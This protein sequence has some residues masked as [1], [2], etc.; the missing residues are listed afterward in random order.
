VEHT[1]LTS[2]PIDETIKLAFEALAQ[3]GC[4]ALVTDTEGNIVYVNR[5][6]CEISGYSPTELIGSN[7]RMLQSGNTPSAT[8]QTLWNS[9][10]S[11]HAW[12]GVIQNRNK[13]GELYWEAVTI[14]PLKNS[15]GAITHF[16]A[17]LEDITSERLAQ[18]AQ[19][20][21][22]EE[23]FQEEKRESL[24]SLALGITE[25]I[26]NSLKA[27]ASDCELARRSIGNKAKISE[28]L[29]KIEASANQGSD[30]LRQ[31]STLWKPKLSARL[32]LDIQRLLTS[33]VEKFRTLVVPSSLNVS[34]ASGPAPVFGDEALINNALAALL[35]NAREA[36]DGEEINL[37]YGTLD[38]FA[39]APNEFFIPCGLNSLSVAYVEVADRGVGMDEYTLR[40]A[41]N[42]FFTNK[43]GH[44]GLGLATLYGI[45][46]AH[47][48]AIG[49]LSSPTRGTTARL[50]FRRLSINSPVSAS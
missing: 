46:S 50:Y 49:V 34:L 6:L 8:Y 21:L 45:M 27:V 47:K 14:S 32:C 18:A 2:H 36:S 15:A 12:H 19:T 7:P 37:S 9:V 31:V 16:S 3:S 30:L 4:G 26:N 17:I 10:S 41:F 35:A 33:S 5:R 39:P 20:E 42:P 38:G 23:I 11:G 25:S 48:G 22:E 28:I 43:A 24:V 29:D 13:K 44:R 40:R 1:V